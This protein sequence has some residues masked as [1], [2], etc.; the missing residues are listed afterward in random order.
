MSTSI[1][2]PGQ[3]R[4]HDVSTPVVEPGAV[5]AEVDQLLDR[6]PDRDAPPMDLK[7]Q[8]QILECA[9]DVLVQALSSVDKS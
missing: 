5:A 6:L 9:H 4:P 1:P 8:A 3:H 7:V 2:L